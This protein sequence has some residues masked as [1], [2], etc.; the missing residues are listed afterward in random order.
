MMA[1]T[2]MLFL[3][4]LYKIKR[5]SVDD[6]ASFNDTFC[7]GSDS[8]LMYGKA[9]SNKEFHTLTF[10]IGHQIREPPVSPLVIHSPNRAEMMVANHN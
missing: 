7:K 6:R 9:M 1:A 3:N 8:D 4:H 5:F 2:K 10:L